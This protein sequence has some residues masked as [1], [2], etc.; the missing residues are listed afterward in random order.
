[1]IDVK[2][3]IEIGTLSV[4]LTMPRIQKLLSLHIMIDLKYNIT[5]MEFKSLVK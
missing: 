1:M 2:N 5:V 4:N 3:A